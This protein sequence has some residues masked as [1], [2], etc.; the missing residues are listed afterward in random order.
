MKRIFFIAL[1]TSALASCQ[2]DKT[3]VTGHEIVQVD[4]E[5]FTL[6]NDT[7]TAG[8]NLD[9]EVTYLLTNGCQS[10]H[11]LAK[12]SNDTSL[13]VRTYAR[14][15]LGVPCTQAI[16]VGSAGV[17]HSFNTSG[18]KMITIENPNL[19]DTSFIVAVQ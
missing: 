12:Q 17:Q 16:T 9:L 3:P 13:I 2:K 18:S 11:H 10:Y 6:P 4:I 1:L 5:N 14:V 15:E 8:Q 19:P 7:I